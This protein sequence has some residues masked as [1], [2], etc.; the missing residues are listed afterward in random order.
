MGWPWTSCKC[1]RPISD[2]ACP[3]TSVPCPVREVQRQRLLWREYRPGP[4][5]RSAEGGK[6]HLT[7]PGYA[8]GVRRRMLAT[9]PR[10]WVEN[11]TG[12]RSPPIHR[13]GEKIRPSGLYVPTAS[14]LRLFYW[15][16]K[17]LPDLLGQIWDTGHGND[18]E[19][20]RI[21]VA[22]EGET[23]GLPHA[24]SHLLVQG[25]RREVGS[26]RRAGAG[27]FGLRRPP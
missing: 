2:S 4:C 17:V 11:T 10:Q 19:A 26:G 5:H 18:H 1:P 3:R 24:V 14:P 9:A 25:G 7:I 23:D 8:S 6:R 20:G 12:H 13:R 21:A 22:G 27:N 15:C 16:F